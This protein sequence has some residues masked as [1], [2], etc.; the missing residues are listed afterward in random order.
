MSHTLKD[1]IIFSMKYMKNMDKDVLNN[2]KEPYFFT[3][4]EYANETGYDFDIPDIIDLESEDNLVKPFEIKLEDIQELFKIENVDNKDLNKI[5]E[6]HNEIK[7]TFDNII[8]SEMK[9]NIRNFKDAYTRGG[10]HFVLTFNAERLILGLNKR[11]FEEIREVI[12]K[13]EKIQ[14]NQ[15]IKVNNAIDNSINDIIPEKG[16]VNIVK[17]YNK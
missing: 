16:I 11:I 4:A 12:K 8:T 1:L 15:D 13:H 3:F 9:N 6:F 10:F 17:K 5:K 7:K 2:L 14:K